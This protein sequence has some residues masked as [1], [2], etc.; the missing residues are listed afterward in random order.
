MAMAP[1]SV[2]FLLRSG[3]SIKDV[4]PAG[5]RLSLYL[6]AAP[7]PASSRDTRLSGFIV[8]FL[9]FQFARSSTKS[10]LL[11]TL[12]PTTLFFWSVPTDV[13]LQK[14]ADGGP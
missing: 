3:R 13:L 7:T 6:L 8:D 1:M 5:A 10:A 4:P 9:T 2:T 14:I 11:E 12:G